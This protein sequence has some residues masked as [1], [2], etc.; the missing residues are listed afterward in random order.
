MKT[1]HTQRIEDNC[2]QENEQEVTVSAKTNS[3]LADSI[4]TQLTNPNQIEEKQQQDMNK[5]KKS[6]V[7]GKKSTDFTELRASTKQPS[8]SKNN[9]HRRDTVMNQARPKPFI[10]IDD[11]NEELQE[12]RTQSMQSPNFGTQFDLSKIQKGTAHQVWFRPGNQVV[13]MDGQCHSLLLSPTYNNQLLT[14][15]SIQ[16]SSSTTSFDVNCFSFNNESQGSNYYAFV[17]PDGQVPNSY[18][19]IG[20]QQFSIIS[21]KNQNIGNM[22]KQG[23][24]IMLLENSLEQFKDIDEESIQ[25]ESSSIE[26]IKLDEIQRSNDK[27]N[28]LGKNSKKQKQLRNHILIFKNPM[29]LLDK[30]AIP[31]IA[32]AQSPLLT[33]RSGSADLYKDRSKEKGTFSTDSKGDKGRR[34]SNETIEDEDLDERTSQTRPTGLQLNQNS[35]Q[36]KDDQ[37]KSA[38]NFQQQQQE[39]DMRVQQQNQMMLG[40]N[41]KI[42]LRLPQGYQQKASPIAIIN[43]PS[44]LQ[45]RESPRSPKVK[46]SGEKFTDMI[47]QNNKSTQKKRIPDFNSIQTLIDQERIQLPSQNESLLSKTHTSKKFNNR[48]I[49]DKAYT[50]QN[51]LKDNRSFDDKLDF[52]MQIR[53]NKQDSND[54][55][56]DF[57]QDFKKKQDQ[58]KLFNFAKN[59]NLNNN[60]YLKNAIHNRHNPYQEDIFSDD[61]VPYRQ[62][63]TGNHMKQTTIPQLDLYGALPQSKEKIKK[64]Y[65]SSVKNSK[66]MAVQDLQKMLDTKQE[67][68]KMEKLIRQDQMMKL[69]QIEK[70]NLQLRQYLNHILMIKLNCD[71]NQ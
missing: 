32:Q 40:S 57:N 28:M 62:S 18:F 47:K 60:M 55:Y 41:Q 61:D 4:L 13:G 5:N 46:H 50:A 22:L 31:N 64:S 14:K 39:E 53:I 7:Y 70:E 11:D 36:K 68:L 2:R 63:S 12:V 3:K 43:N 56:I 52:N 34:V 42:F 44:K 10:N 49:Q 24:K 20:D 23:S 30:D 21:P 8:P 6:P 54:E 16:G 29:G 17:G 58:Q 51:R 38:L 59:N 33:R 27:M 48:N 26:E 25:D 69:K 71:H 37:N 35:I 67:Q 1:H 65:V 15:P 19:K 66:D 45:G 9:D